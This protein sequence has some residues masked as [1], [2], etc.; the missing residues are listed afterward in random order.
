VIP[1]SGA[2][3]THPSSP[4]GVVIFRDGPS[5]GLYAADS[6]SGVLKHVLTTYV[7]GA[8][9]SPDGRR[10]AFTR[11]SSGSLGYELW[12]IGVG[13]RG[14]SRLVTEG[15]DG[16]SQVF[17][18]TFSWSPDGKKIAFVVNTTSRTGIS[19]VD[20]RTRRIVPLTSAPG[21]SE[22][23]D[24]AWSP[25]GKRIA[26]ERTRRARTSATSGSCGRTGRVSAASP[27]GSP[28]SAHR[29]GRPTDDGLP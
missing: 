28:S 17:W 5:A 18:S 4:V 24:P 1:S 6:Q 16:L 15:A 19:A 25:D 11:D 29:S 3:R 9:W 8:R 10:I 22:D 20:V 14:L 7:A 26:F 13:G 27:A 23:T 21:M 2:A 12:V